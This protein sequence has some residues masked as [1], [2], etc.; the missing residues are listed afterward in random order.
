MNDNPP[1]FEQQTL[2]LQIAEDELLGYE[3]MRI[4]AHG[5]DTSEIVTYRLEAPEE[6]AKYLSVEHDSGRLLK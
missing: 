2:H 4:K 3:L 5:G 6:I 1:V